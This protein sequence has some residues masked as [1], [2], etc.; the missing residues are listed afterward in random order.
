MDKHTMELE[1]NEVDYFKLPICYNTNKMKIDKDLA[2]DLEL[3]EGE[4]TTYHTL[5][6]CSSNW[7]KR[8]IQQYSLYYT[9]D[10]EFLKQTQSV[11]QTIK[12]ITLPS[13]ENIN[14]EFDMNNNMIA[15]WDEIKKDP[16]FK[17]RYG[18]ISW[19]E[20]EFFNQSTFC[21]NLLVLSFIVT[22][23]LSFMSPIVALMIPFIIL[24]VKRGLDISWS[25]YMDILKSG[26]DQQPIYKL[27]MNFT[28]ISAS[29]KI[30]G[31]ISIVFYVYS[32]YQNIKNFNTF[33][34]N[35][36]KIHQ[37]IFSI[38][39]YLSKMKPTME[40]FVSKYQDQT[41]YQP[42]IDRTQKHILTIGDII[43]K[44]THIPEYNM[45]NIMNFGGV[46]KEFYALYTNAEYNEAVEY[47]FGFYGYIES[48]YSINSKIEKNALSR[49][50]Y[51]KKE[52]R[53]EFC[54]MVYPNVPSTTPN[55]ISLKTNGII[56]GPNASGKTTLLKTVVINILLSQ[57]IGYGY[58]KKAVLCPYKYI[59]C[60]LNIPDTSGRDSLFQSESRK[61]K[62]IID[63]INHNPSERHYCMF[64]ELYSG[65][66]PS[67]ATKCG[68]A[69]LLYL[70]KQSHV[71][72]LLTTHYISICKK[73]NSEKNIQNYHMETS[74]NTQGN[75][76]YLYKI[77]QGITTI[78][79]GIE[80][81]K[82]LD[83]PSEIIKIVNTIE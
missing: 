80:V 5:M 66:N 63:I 67:E 1:S 4:N 82:Q 16:I 77:L 2:N 39:T 27:F 8:V 36:K 47:S 83:Y 65:T 46:L 32:T 18:Y 72:F 81:L 34:T 35:M 71:S 68:I 30:Y 31:I 45:I 42:F 61:C 6:D 24:M 7:G 14:N 25:Q 54:K 33:R 28:A 62:N 49:V 23:I 76:K 38:R 20:V 43:H 53:T 15:S 12:E 64:D 59:H 51:T 22:P 70:S 3:I 37:Y 9:T 60:Y 21:L 10:T 75:I 58:F 78:D 74:K 48:L 50:T 11:I 13:L 57:Q 44:L 17:E 79:G 26:M 52:K 41:T 19:K 40:Q 55:T 56:S 73:L 69:F 29:E